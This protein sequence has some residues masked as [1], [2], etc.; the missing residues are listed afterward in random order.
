MGY[1]FGL[2]K[3]FVCAYTLFPRQE[4]FGKMPFSHVDT[5]AQL[6]LKFWFLLTR[7]SIII[8]L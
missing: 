6:S 3:V 2:A 7:G 5:S 1:L 4:R 8:L